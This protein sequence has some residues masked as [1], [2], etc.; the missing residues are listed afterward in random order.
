MRIVFVLFD[1][2]DLMDFA[3]PFEALLTANRLLAREGAAPAFDLVTVSPTG[4]PVLAYGGVPVTPHREAAD[5][6]EVGVVVVP[7]TIDIDAALADPHLVD[8][9][10]K[11]AANCSVT[12]SVC[13][14]AFLL[15]EAGVLHGRTWTTHWE[16]IPL[17]SQRLDGGRRER[18]VDTG[19]V[20]TAGGIGCGIDLGLHLVA[21]LADP[22]LARGC[23][24]QMDVPWGD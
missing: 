12:T 14:G 19:A 20:I 7:G 10:R 23:A 1:G 4:E 18:V 15:A 16:D 2:M 5:V 11:L 17:L 13:T 22:A 21:R 3:G 24:R 9:V 6:A 8:T